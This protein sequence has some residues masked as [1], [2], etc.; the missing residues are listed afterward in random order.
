MYGSFSVFQCLV[1]IVL[2]LLCDELVH[3]VSG[4]PCEVMVYRGQNTAR[5]SNLGL[6]HLPSDMAHDIKVL[7]FVENQLST[8][9]ADYFRGYTSLQEIT[10]TQNGITTI[11]AD[12]FR[13]LTNVQLLDLE[14]NLI[15]V[16]PVNAFRHIP[17]VRSINFKNNRIK[18]ISKDSFEYLPNIESIT[19]ENCIIERIHP[20]VFQ[21]LD[22]LTDINLV[23]NELTTLDD[24]M[25]AALPPKLSVFRLYRN[26]WNC[27][28][29]LRWLRLWI[30]TSNI[31]WDFSRNT[32]ACS[33]PDIIRGI[34]WKHMTPEQ[35]ACASRILATPVPP[36]RWSGTTI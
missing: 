28:C 35:F 19:F 27:D 4:H 16:F 24:R 5:C 21:N 3:M 23:N 10:M 15:I 33:S 32:P 34:S 22:R 36:W 20:L 25:G 31:N 29:R 17:S 30:D 9:G 7:E 13:G 11:T 6:D 14:D 1:S 18:F 8:L 26:P 12:A 2:L